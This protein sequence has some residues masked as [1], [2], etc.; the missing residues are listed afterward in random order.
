MD[1][2]FWNDFSPR[3]YQVRTHQLWEEYVDRAQWCSPK[4]EK[5][6]YNIPGGMEMS[7]TTARIPISFPID[8]PFFTG[9]FWKRNT[10]P[11]VPLTQH[12][13]F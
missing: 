4:R 6:C 8:L 3:T 7:P 2:V 12:R 9:H 11:E 1:T 13:H 5:T 10:G